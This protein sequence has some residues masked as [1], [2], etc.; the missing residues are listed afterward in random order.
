MC[1]NKIKQILK[2]NKKLSMN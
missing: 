1:F 2:Y